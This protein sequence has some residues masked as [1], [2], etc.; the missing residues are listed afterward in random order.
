MKSNPSDRSDA[1]G[2]HAKGFFPLFT[3]L[4]SLIFLACAVATGTVNGLLEKE[5]L[6]VAGW[7]AHHWPRGE[8]YRLFSSAFLTFGGLG[9]WGSWISLSVILG[10]TEFRL[11]HWPVLILFWGGH[12]VT[13]LL[14]DFV[15]LGS[16]HLGGVGLGTTLWHTHDV[17]PSAGYYTCLGV[18]VLLCPARPLVPFAVSAVVSF[19]VGSLLWH[20]F[21]EPVNYTK[22]IADLAHA[23]AFLLGIVAFRMTPGIR[24]HSKAQGVWQCP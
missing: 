8:L 4:M 15:L 2:K 10:L 12:L 7:A 22:V 23:T 9:F 5:I 6:K 1:S 3:V 24:N 16:L 11:G 13:L 21:R 18:L 19:I 14:L 17:G 20:L